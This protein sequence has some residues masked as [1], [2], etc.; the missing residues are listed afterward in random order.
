MAS[1][2][3]TRHLTSMLAS[4]AAVNLLA[5]NSAL[6]ES[7]FAAFMVKTGRQH[8][9]PRRDQR[10]DT[11]QLQ[12]GQLMNTDCLKS[13]TVCVDSAFLLCHQAGLLWL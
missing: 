13:T 9:S 7:K 3:P 8:R 2:L 10:R 4:A 6:F 1:S 11:I 5:A 12:C